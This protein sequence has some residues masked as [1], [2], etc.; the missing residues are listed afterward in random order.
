MNK[1]SKEI[2]NYLSDELHLEMSGRGIAF[3]IPISSVG[4][5]KVLEAL[6]GDSGEHN[7]IGERK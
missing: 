1:K 3:T 4:G 7:E 5:M 2:L 6:R